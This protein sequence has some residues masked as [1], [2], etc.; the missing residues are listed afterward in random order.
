[1]QIGWAGPVSFYADTIAAQIER[2]FTRYRKGL[3]R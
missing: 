1:V 2:V 3:P